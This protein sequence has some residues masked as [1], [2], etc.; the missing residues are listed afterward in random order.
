MIDRCLECGMALSHPLCHSCLADESVHFLLDHKPKL[1]PSLKKVHS[2][3]LPEVR[4]IVPCVSCKDSVIV[5]PGCF[6]RHVA[7]WLF[8]ENAIIARLFKRQMGLS[9]PIR[10]SK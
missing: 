5:C 4:S 1:I 8:R 9:D 10:D 2:L 3:E 7:L 6:N